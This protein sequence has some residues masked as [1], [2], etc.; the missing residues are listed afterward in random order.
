MSFE[1]TYSEREALPAVGRRADPTL[2]AIAEETTKLRSW[3][4]IRGV[5]LAGQP[6]VRI[7]GDEVTVNVPT[8]APADTNRETGVFP[9][10]LPGGRVVSVTGVPFDNLFAVADALREDLGR[11]P[12]LPVE[13]H[14]GSEGFGAGT[15]TVP[16]P[17]DGGQGQTAVR[18]GTPVE[19]GR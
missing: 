7:S 19:V 14:P 3:A 12:G 9:G 5:R 11:G 16:I 8:V 17:A 18:A 15:V 6:F 2:G 1:T 4:A 10:D 13:F